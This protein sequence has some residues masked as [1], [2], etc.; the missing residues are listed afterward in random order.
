MSDFNAS[1]KKLHAIFERILGSKNVYFQ[2]PENLKLKYPCI[3]Y[4]LNSPRVL[5]ADDII[6]LKRRRYEVTYINSD[7]VSP[8][9]DRIHEELM[10][11][12]FDR[13]FVSDNMYHDV[14]NLYY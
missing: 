8:V 10:Y 4:T 1:R 7:P 13:R 6:F 11:C 2:P 9:T 14:F 3:V 12:H 5:F